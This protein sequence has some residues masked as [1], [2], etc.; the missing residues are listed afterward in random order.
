MARKLARDVRVY[1]VGGAVRDELLGRAVADRDYVVVG[2]TPEMMI[3]SGYRPVG[4]D[5]P[6]FLHPETHEE[7]ALARTER[8][9]GTGYRGFEF[10][11]SPDV[12]LE[13]DLARRDLTIN[14]M[15]RDEQGA[16][17]DPFHG[18]DDLARGILR[19][20]SPAFAEDPL[21]VLRVARFAARFGFRVAP[22]TRALMRRIAASG[23]L[24]TISPERI[25]RELAIGL[26]EATPSRM[27]AVL[28][29]CGALAP[30]L[31]EVDAL[32]G[33]PAPADALTRPRGASSDA[34]LRMLQAL[35]RAAA[36]GDDL[37]V[38]YATIV[39]MLGAAV[40]GATG[41]T[42]ARASARRAD[43]VSARLKAP[44][45]C[46][47]AGRLAALY[48]T[49]VQQGVALTPTRLLDVVQGCDALRR[50]RRLAIVLRAAQHDACAG[51]RGRCAFPQADAIESARAAIAAVDAGAVARAATHDGKGVEHV[52]DVRAAIRR[53]RLAALSRWK[54]ERGAAAKA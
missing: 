49:V 26:G 53:A 35:D 25:W 16:I 46:R 30:L 17:I 52:D 48:R 14:A 33:V 6:V 54:R 10:F 4:S 42:L 50:P 31:P 51:A 8:K 5:F 9:H 41:G 13:E 2:A 38:R 23:E 18:R 44:L 40:A 1:E 47:D 36:D 37:P 20:V 39:Q 24:A 11:A 15:A 12:T 34:G 32:F 21:R 29:D 22:A 45:E 19:H 43:A 3:A 27:I 28:R 7:H